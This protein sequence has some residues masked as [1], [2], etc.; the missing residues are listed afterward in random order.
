MVSRM[1]GVRGIL[2]QKFR[3]AVKTGWL[4][5]AALN[6]R[7]FVPLTTMS[8]WRLPH[9]EQTSL[10]RHSRTEVFSAVAACMLGGIRLYLMLTISAPD[11]QPHTGSRGLAECHR[12]PGL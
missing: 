1:K 8:T 7:G 12:R 2:R 10:S 5:G 6:Y 3:P 11:D 4:E 9:R